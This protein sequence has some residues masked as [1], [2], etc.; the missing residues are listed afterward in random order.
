MLL[1][2]KPA[3]LFLFALT[4]CLYLPALSSIL[5]N[6]IDASEE[7]LSLS[8]VLPGGDFT[9]INSVLGG[10]ILPL[11]LDVENKDVDTGILGITA[12]AVIG[13]R[14]ECRNIQV[15]EQGDVYLSGEFL[16]G[17]TDVNGTLYSEYVFQVLVDLVQFECDIPLKVFVFSSGEDEEVDG[18]LNFITS[19]AQVSQQ[20][21]LFSPDYT[22]TVPVESEIGECVADVGSV[23]YSGEGLLDLLGFIDLTDTVLEEIRNDPTLVQEDIQAEL[24]QLANDLA[25]EIS[26]LLLTND[27]VNKSSDFYV[28]NPFEDGT[29]LQPERGLASEFPD[30]NIYDWTDRDEFFVDLLLPI[31]ADTGSK[32]V[33]YDIIDVLYPQNNTEYDSLL[34]FL[35]EEYNL[36]MHEND[37]TIIDFDL[38]SIFSGEFFATSEEIASGEA[39]IEP[40]E[41]EF[42]ITIRDTGLAVDVRIVIEELLLDIFPPENATSDPVFPNLIAVGKQTL[43]IPKINLGDIVLTGDIRVLVNI[44]NT[45]TVVEGAEENV[46]LDNNPF[47]ILLDENFQV[48]LDWDGFLA[49]LTALIPPDVDFFNA[50]NLG[51]IYDE[52]FDCLIACLVLTPRVTGLT[53][54][55]EFVE[56]SLGGFEDAFLVLVG[57]I[58]NTIIPVYQPII[59]RALELLGEESVRNQELIDPT[60]CLPADPIYD[61]I[62]LYPLDFNEGIFFNISDALDNETVV[63]LLEFVEFENGGLEILSP[64]D[65]LSIDFTLPVINGYE[66]DMNISFVYIV[67]AG[68]T[69]PTLRDLKVLGVLEDSPYYP[70]EVTTY[71]DAGAQ[72]NP[73]ILRIELNVSV[74]EPRNV[75][76]VATAPPEEFLA[77]SNYATIE[78][79]FASVYVLLDLYLKFTDYDLDSMELDQILSL[80]CWLMK[81]DYPG[82][83]TQFIG[84]LEGLEVSVDCECDNFILNSMA[85]AL[86]TETSWIDLQEF[87]QDVVDGVEPLLQGLF[88][89][90]DFDETIGNARNICMTGS[91][92]SVVF[93]SFVAEPSEDYIGVLSYLALLMVAIIVPA[94]LGFC[95]KFCGPKWKEYRKEEI[96]KQT[97]QHEKNIH[98][99]EPMYR[100]SSIPK[101]AKI[102]IPLCIVLNICLFVIGDTGVAVIINIVGQILGVTLNLENFGTLSVITTAITLW[103]TG[104]YI[105]AL[106]L[107]IVSVGWPYM[108]LLL[109]MFSW[110][111][112][113]STMSLEKRGVLLEW[114]DILGRY[115][116]AEFHFLVFV[117]LVFNIEGGSPNPS[118]LGDEEAFQLLIDIQPQVSLF[119]F[120]MA[121]VFSII[122]S[123]ILLVL[124]NNL[125]DKARIRDRKEFLQRI[126]AVKKEAGVITH[127][128]DEDKFYFGLG[129]WEFNVQS[130]AHNVEHGGKDYNYTFKITGAALSLLFVSISVVAVTLLYAATLESIHVEIN[131]IAGFLVDWADRERKY[132]VSVFDLLF[133][134]VKIYEGNTIIYFVASV[135]ILT[136]VVFPALQTLVLFAMLFGQYTLSGAR[137]LYEAHHIISVWCCVDVFV[138][139]ISLTVLELPTVAKGLV[140]AIEECDFLGDLM[141]E[142]LLPLGLIE[143]EDAAASC[144][145]IHSEVTLGGY[146]C[147]LVVLLL[148]FANLFVGRL[149]HYYIIDRE[150][151][152]HVDGESSH[153]HLR[154][155]HSR[156]IKPYHKKLA[157]YGLI[158][159][160]DNTAKAQRQWEDTR[161]VQ[162]VNPIFS[163]EASEGNN[164]I[165]PSVLQ[166]DTNSRVAGSTTGNSLA[167]QP[168]RSNVL[169][170]RQRKQVI[171]QMRDGIK[172]QTPGNRLSQQMTAFLEDEGPNL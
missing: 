5:P 136:I 14:G 155:S 150:K 101:A 109:L 40:V 67:L 143:E 21:R 171:L 113:P 82:G 142:F 66:T 19:T 138:I 108:K 15:M 73:L 119:T 44:S 68:I 85:A 103:D 117:L 48:Q 10:M 172:P 115:S 127:E 27:L 29:Y 151:I 53:V 118:W 80:D 133:D 139:A 130:N 7:S 72:D 51:P 62:E 93:T 125:E 114:L 124:N 20:L 163:A 128:I 35:S 24:C 43:E 32:P 26:N 39:I 79:K 45:G 78:L 126:E 42:N 56:V 74:P 30:V 137:H 107:F 168:V 64:D 170:K 84:E 94:G 83:V 70:Q 52:I 141:E 22:T 33:L 3:V 36:H 156:Q 76:G 135:F 1:Y 164:S 9:N 104:A 89:E 65:D 50:I 8:R 159:I 25:G 140:E 17:Q 4:Q 132:D 90:E 69:P 16:D 147:I 116:F 47:E 55:H 13:E 98:Y 162:V 167:Y 57:D 149:F 105:L 122:L 23:E 131:G 110:F 54:D 31:P 37:G 99:L 123:N 81:L 120:S 148:N 166:G 129:Q 28:A 153:D 88:R 165:L 144:I 154:I 102:L 41:A 34:W 61:D 96:S 12:V 2:L 111:S 97:Q 100:N 91:D 112:S 71:L 146:L 145:G 86:N 160:E 75:D 49:R 92:D 158:R 121:V 106:L 63:E 60:E 87:L 46:L 38:R 11:D 95:I 134:I 157:S 18:T 77:Q 169:K 6:G 59:P 58:V 161:Q 152:I